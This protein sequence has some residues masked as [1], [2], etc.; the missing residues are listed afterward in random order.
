MTTSPRTAGAALAD[1]GRAWTHLHRTPRCHYRRTRWYRG[2]LSKH[3][4]HSLAFASLHMPATCIPAIHADKLYARFDD[5]RDVH[6]LA[7]KH[8]P[9]RWRFVYR[10]AAPAP[11]TLCCG[12]DFCP[13]AHTARRDA[14]ILRCCSSRHR[15]AHAPIKSGRAT[16]ALHSW[17]ATYL[18]LLPELGRAAAW[19]RPLLQALSRVSLPFNGCAISRGLFIMRLGAHSGRRG[20][21]IVPSRLD[22]RSKHRLLTGVLA[23]HRWP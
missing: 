14:I 22:L 18:D 2:Y 6:S 8:L 9:Q 12:F 13:T 10:H 19:A 5:A 1:G 3:Q 23:H 4:R 16:Q 17:R 21:I 11:R 20:R 15:R 7:L